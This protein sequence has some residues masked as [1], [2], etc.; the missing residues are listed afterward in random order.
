MF[1][2]TGDGYMSFALSLIFYVIEMKFIFYEIKPF[3]KKDLPFEFCVPYLCFD[4]NLVSKFIFFGGVNF[5]HRTFEEIL[6]IS[7]MLLVLCS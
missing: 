5:S 4:K 7:V 2:E 6:Q 1:I 3:L